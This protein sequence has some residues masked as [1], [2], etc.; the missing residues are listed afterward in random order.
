MDALVLRLPVLDLAGGAAELCGQ[1]L[2]REQAS[3]GWVREEAAQSD[4]RGCHGRRPFG[5][6]MVYSDT[7][8]YQ[9]SYQDEEDL[10]WVTWACS[11]SSKTGEWGIRLHPEETAAPREHAHAQGS[12]R[13]WSQ[14]GRRARV[15]KSPCTFPSETGRGSHDG[16]VETIV[17]YV[18]HLF[19]MTAPV[20]VL[21]N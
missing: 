7:V 21:Y 18:K 6:A 12:L 19:N 3:Q 14:A 9:N 1:G 10:E 2:V 13:F 8:G 15:I 11:Y 4:H 17:R 16:R 20:S 5:L